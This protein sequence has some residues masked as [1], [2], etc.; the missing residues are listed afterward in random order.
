M[1][2]ELRHWRLRMLSITVVKLPVRERAPE[3]ELR[4]DTM[5]RISLMV[6]G[7]RVDNLT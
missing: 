7:G 1:M 4:S 5:E 3:F 2:C 6:R